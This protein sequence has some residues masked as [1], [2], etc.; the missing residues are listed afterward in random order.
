[1]HG[2]RLNQQIA[3]FFFSFVL[4]FHSLPAA[5]IIYLQGS[6]SSGKSTLIRG[7]QEEVKDIIVVDEDSI[8]HEA[9]VAAVAKRFPVQFSQIQ[10]TIAPENLYHALRE[11]EILFKKNA[12]DGAQAKSKASLKSI[13]DELDSPENLPWKQAISKSIDSQVLSQISE[14]LLK[15]N[16]V[17][18][19]SWYIKPKR[20]KEEFPDKPI[21]RVLLYSPLAKAYE[22]FLRRNKLAA[23]QGN[24]LEKR[25]P[26]QLLGSF[27]SL[28]Q[29]SSD[30]EQPIHRIQKSTL[31]P[32]LEA[33]SHSFS[34]EE[35]TYNK[36]V[37]T[38]QE[39]SFAYFLQLKENFLRPFEKNHDL[40]ISPREPQDIIIDNTENE[41]RKAVLL[42]LKSCPFLKEEAHARGAFLR[43][44]HASATSAV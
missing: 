33:I 18:L 39:P 40:Y 11:K 44:L 12:D 1:M 9:Y 10:L 43:P 37:F 22:R 6:C 26:R 14:A 15:G 7:L 8:M 32:T 24:L 29:I 36:P 20:L 35:P 27:F 16:H 31:E 17:L 42:L 38:F 3:L 5:T 41:A 30:H 25:Y 13:Q 19:D 28:Y 23:E 4:F 34:G 2:W 21:I